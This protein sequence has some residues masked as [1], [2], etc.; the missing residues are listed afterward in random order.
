ML[1]LFPVSVVG[2]CTCETKDLYH[3]RPRSPATDSAQPYSGLSVRASSGCHQVCQNL[4][5]PAVYIQFPNLFNFNLFHAVNFF[6]GDT[7]LIHYGFFR[8]T[9][10]FSS[11]NLCFPHPKPMVF[12]SE[13]GCL[14]RLLWVSFVGVFPHAKRPC[15]MFM[16]S[17]STTETG[18]PYFALHI[19]NDKLC[20]PHAKPVPSPLVSFVGEA[21]TAKPKGALQNK[22][23]SS[24]KLIFSYTCC[25]IEIRICSL[26]PKTDPV[27]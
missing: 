15:R 1:A 25:T 12:V 3:I 18:L 14:V 17:T 11:R 10:G 8:R 19:R 13:T 5:L 24:V 23:P 4:L 2:S 6:L 16:L 7:M 21:G 26:R 27:L 20:F 9:K 22:T